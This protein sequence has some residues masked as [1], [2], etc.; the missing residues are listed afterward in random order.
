M[1]FLYSDI[2]PC[3]IFVETLFNPPDDNLM[4]ALPTCISSTA[5]N[6]AMEFF[7]SSP[8]DLKLTR[9]MLAKCLEAHPTD[10]SLIE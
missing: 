3:N 1:N 5:L 10:A 4:T 2:L 8:D 7:M 6:G 9:H